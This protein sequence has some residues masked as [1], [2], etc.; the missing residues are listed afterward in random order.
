[1]STINALPTAAP[2]DAPLVA[3]PDASN[4][5]DAKGRFLRGNKGGPGNPLAGQVNKVRKAFLEFFAGRAM[6]VLCDFMFRKALSGDPR[7][8]RLILQYTIGK[9]PTDDV[10]AD[11]DAFNAAQAEAEAVAELAEEIERA[12]GEEPPAAD[13]GPQDADDP[14]PIANREHAADPKPAGQPAVREQVS[15]PPPLEVA[16]ATPPGTGVADLANPPHSKNRERL[17]KL[18]DER[19]PLRGDFGAGPPSTNGIGDARHIPLVGT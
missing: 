18:L 15:V 10:F 12:A 2:P 3:P 7:F 8:V 19:D 5:R 6:Q 11:E 13:A 4:D 14:S 17:L 16:L 9:L 1:M